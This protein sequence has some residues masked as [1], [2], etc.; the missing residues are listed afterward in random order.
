MP[1]L[2]ISVLF[3]VGSTGFD[4][5]ANKRV[6]EAIALLKADGS[7]A[8]ALSGFVDSSGSAAVNE[9]LARN[10]AVA[11]RDALVAAGISV[12]RIEM[13]KHGMI[14]AGTVDDARARRVDIVAR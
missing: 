4:D 14:E 10:R 11:V 7:I 12:D 2:P 9:E 13:R 5:A 1:K 6:A 8:V 3:A